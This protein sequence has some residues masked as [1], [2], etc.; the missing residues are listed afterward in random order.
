MAAVVDYLQDNDIGQA[1]SVV[2]FVVC[3]D[4]YAYFQD[5]GDASPAEDSLVKL[6]GVTLTN[7]SNL[8]G[9]AI[10]PVVLDLDGDGVEF[11]SIAAGV[12]YDYDGDGNAEATAWVGSDDAI[13]AI[14]ANA[15]GQ[16]TD[17]SEFVFGGDGM[18]DLEAVAANYDEN[19]DG[20][21]D[22]SDSAFEQF[23]IWQDANQNGVSDPGEFLTL[24]EAGIASIGVVSDNVDA[25]GAGGDVTVFGSSVFTYANGETGIVADTAFET[26][27]A[28]SAVGNPVLREAANQ[29]DL[30]QSQTAMVAALSGA[31]LSEPAVEAVTDG[32]KQTGD[33]SDEKAAVATVELVSFAPGFDDNADDAL[34]SFFANGIEPTDSVLPTDGL[35]DESASEPLSEGLS[36]EPVEPGLNKFSQSDDEGSTETHEAFML[37]SSASN[38]DQSMEALLAM[39][40]GA[41]TDV[42]VG[43]PSTEAGLVLSD[44]AAEIALDQLIDGFEA[45]GVTSEFLIADLGETGVGLLDQALE[46]GSY[47][48]APVS[49][50]EN[51]IDEAAAAAAAAA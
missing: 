25:L 8:V 7:V 26:A 2:A 36:D 10:L 48:L 16:V 24:T 46:P 27:P 45:E 37:D 40:E 42:L 32:L 9:S 51:Q 4:T 19:G 18:S 28:Q 29:N 31:L 22:A 33:V 11:V 41:S 17:A 1:N 13:L 20:V 3:Y 38:V 23:G 34:E 15:D 47:S 49:A 6:L 30:R 12:S 50:G 39:A 5:N 14:D 35:S 43:E 21:L 44:V